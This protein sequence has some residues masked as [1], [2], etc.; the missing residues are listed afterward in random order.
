[1]TQ[2]TVPRAVVA[3]VEPADYARVAAYLAAYPGEKRAADVWLKRFGLW[4]DDNPA[5]GGDVE[6]GWF[7]KDGDRVVGF[8]GNVP[9]W[10]QTPRGV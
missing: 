10:F 3:A 5:F 6:R 7:L 4:W 2:A 9:T 8:L 1:M